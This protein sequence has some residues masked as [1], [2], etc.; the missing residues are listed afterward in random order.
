MSYDFKTLLIVLTMARL[1]QSAG[2]LYVW[3]L[4]QNYRPARDWALGSASVALGVLVV[5]LRDALPL[6]AVIL[7]GFSAIFAGTLIFNLGI[8]KA[9]SCRAPLKAG[10]IGVG[11]AIATACWFTLVEPSLLGRMAPSWRRW[12][13]STLARRC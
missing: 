2:L 5:A 13:R 11:I 9:A 12:W 4:H 10:L 8:L 1:L 6:A 7:I 3:R